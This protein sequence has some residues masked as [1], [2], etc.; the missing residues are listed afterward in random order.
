MG[1]TSLALLFWLAGTA[2]SW[3]Q[4]NIMQFS[5]YPPDPLV[6]KLMGNYR[7]T[8]YAAGEIDAD[9]GKRLAKLIADKHI[10]AASLL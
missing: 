9:A 7:W 10:P 6:Q 8:I 2:I 3:C 4:P 1:R 5:A